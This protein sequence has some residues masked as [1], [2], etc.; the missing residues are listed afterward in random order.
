MTQTITMYHSTTT[1][2]NDATLN[3]FLTKGI[4]RS[5]G[6]VDYSHQRNGFFVN[7]SRQQEE[8]H[9]RNYHK[10]KE[11]PKEGRP[12]LLTVRCRFGA[13][14]DI[15]YEE[16]ADTAKS[17]LFHCQDTLKHIPAGI[18]KLKEGHTIQ[19]VMPV[20]EGKKDGL[21]ITLSASGQQAE[22]TIFMPWDNTMRG[23]AVAQAGLL[24]VLRDYL[25]STLGKEYLAHE[26]A[27]VMKIIEKNRVKTDYPEGISMKA[28]GPKP[29]EIEKIEVWNGKSWD[30]ITLPGKG[31][32]PAPRK[33]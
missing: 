2:K 21:D 33:R 7:S 16:D 4:S 20:Y 8:Q 30:D 12:L 18:L 25:V 27:Q 1:G 11:N 26:Q 24:Q 13:G 15:D 32:T 3:A 14:F 29:P 10:D 19:R 28:H 5:K 17:I 23:E 9:A 31:Q 22:H 6:Y